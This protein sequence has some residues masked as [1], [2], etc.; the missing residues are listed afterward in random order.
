MH[1]ASATIA[2]AQDIHEITDICMCF[3]RQLKNYALIGMKMTYYDPAADLTKNTKIID[4]YIT[5]SR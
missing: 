2:S 1:D 3:Q 5:E 4:Q